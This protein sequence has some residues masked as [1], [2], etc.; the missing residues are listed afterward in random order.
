MLDDVFHSIARRWRW[1]VGVTILM[2][3]LGLALGLLW[4]DRYTATASVTVESITIGEQTQD[5]NMETQRLVARS[6]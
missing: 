1:L 2:T 3:L 4:P 5:V 6:T